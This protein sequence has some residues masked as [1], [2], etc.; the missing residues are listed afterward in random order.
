MWGFGFVATKWALTGFPALWMTVVR[1]V[2][3]FLIAMPILA[4]WT[5]QRSALCREDL[6]LARTPG[7][8][9]AALMAFQ[10]LGIQ[11]TTVT[12]SSFITTLYVVIVPLLAAL[13]TRE[14]I[15]A[16][17]WGLVL[18][19]LGGTALICRLETLSVN[20]GDAL[21]L[22]A[23]IAASYHMLVIEKAAPRIRSAFGFNLF[24][25]AWAAMATIPIALLV[26][27]A[28]AFTFR[29]EAKALF[30]FFFLVGP[31][32]LVAF[33]LQV[34]AQRVL[35]AVAI[36]LLFL[37]ESPYA[38]TFGYLFLDERPV[39]SQWAGA[40]LILA[41]A[42]GAVWFAWSNRRRSGRLDS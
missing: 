14:K 3:A 20:I 17:H 42:G 35:P 27:P 40:G 11:Y 32:T 24:Q 7:L 15:R 1:F 36:S 30:G 12:N 23:A 19:A 4:V 28:P 5:S 9:L 39:A 26:D 29:P 25:T 31:C 16:S 13:H 34:S 37:L 6:R 2:A 33:A 10:T 22:L 18:L 8:W 41:A 21:T 38:A